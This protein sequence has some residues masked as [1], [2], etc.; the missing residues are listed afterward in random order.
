MTKFKTASGMTLEE[1]N[2]HIKEMEDSQEEAEKIRIEL[3]IGSD[4]KEEK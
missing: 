4:Q 2:E 1:L 3:R